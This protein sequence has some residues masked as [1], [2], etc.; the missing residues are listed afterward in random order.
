MNSVSAK[1][2]V[3]GVCAAAAIAAASAGVA[4]GAGSA[5]AVEI[6]QDNRFTVL[7]LTHAETRQ[8][9]DMG[10]VHFLDQPGIIEHTKVT[11]RA[12]SHLNYLTTSEGGRHLFHGSKQQLVAEAAARPGGRIG[13]Y[14]DRTLP[15][16]PLGIVQYWPTR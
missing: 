5:H 10:L 16:R 11:V 14:L 6:Q 15:N 7:W 4:G 9:A 3:A 1:R 2:M 8:A 12:D 13:V